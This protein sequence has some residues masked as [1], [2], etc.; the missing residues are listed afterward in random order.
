VGINLD[1]MI[2]R[3]IDIGKATDF[4]KCGK[5]I[6]ESILRTELEGCSICEKER[7]WLFNEIEKKYPELV[8]TFT[9]GQPEVSYN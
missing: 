4:P 9:I 8:W 3:L 6:E 1:K 7:T 5:E 2:R